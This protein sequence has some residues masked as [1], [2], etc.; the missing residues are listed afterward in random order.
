MATMMAPYQYASALKTS[1]SFGSSSRG[2]LTRFA[3]TGFSFGWLGRTGASKG[4]PWKRP[5]IDRGMGEKEGPVLLH[6]LWTCRKDIRILTSHS[7]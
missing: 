2:V 6:F 1:P 3:L 4:G 5:L 7:L